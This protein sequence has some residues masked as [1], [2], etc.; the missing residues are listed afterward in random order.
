MGGTSAI[1]DE[2]AMGTAGTYLLRGADAAPPEL[3]LLEAVDDLV[4]V[5]DQVSAVRDEE[6]PVAVKPCRVAR[7]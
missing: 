6:T 3:D 1:E 7:M 4:E 5:E 2:V